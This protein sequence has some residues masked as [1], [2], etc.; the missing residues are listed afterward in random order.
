MGEGP[1]KPETQEQQLAEMQQAKERLAGI[2]ER[3][4]Q[5]QEAKQLSPEGEMMLIQIEEKEKALE[6]SIAELMEHNKEI[7]NLKEEEVPEEKKD[8]YFGLLSDS[9]EKATKRINRSTLST[10]AS[11]AGVMVGSIA[12]G[13]TGTID[14]DLAKTIGTIAA[15]T[16]LA[17]TAAIA[18]VGHG[19]ALVRAKM[20][21]W[22]HNFKENAAF[23][24]R[25]RE[26]W[27][28]K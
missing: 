21:E 26:A 1:P 12:L 2:R 27:G 28:N 4:A 23:E 7:E 24:K 19:Y 18:T 17:G 16:N 15:T 6:A 25:F 3:A 8:W 5:A 11:T 22:V 20:S 14:S 10:Y 13:A 9:Y